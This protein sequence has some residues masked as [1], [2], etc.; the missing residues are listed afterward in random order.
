M[1]PLF[2]VMVLVHPLM[3][4][5]RCRRRAHYLVANVWACVT[6]APFYRFELVELENLPA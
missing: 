3:L 1:I 4:F 5:D 6:I 2:A